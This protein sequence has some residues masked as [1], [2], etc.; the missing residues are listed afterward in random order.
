[1]NYAKTLGKESMLTTM[2]DL[3][4]KYGERFTADA[5]WAAL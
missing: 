1:V 5:G 3:K 4:G 2:S